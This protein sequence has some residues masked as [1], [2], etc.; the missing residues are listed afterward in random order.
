MSKTTAVLCAF[1]FTIGILILALTFV[2][3]PQTEAEPYQVRKSDTVTENS[4]GYLLSYY[5]TQTM[6]HG[7]YIIALVIGALTLISRWQKFAE[8]KGKEILSKRV[9]IRCRWIIFIFVISSIIA[10]GVYMIGRTL[11]WGALASKVM[12]TKVDEN[13]I[14]VNNIDKRTIMHELHKKTGIAV[15]TGNLTI[16]EQLA[17]ASKSDLLV[18]VGLIIGVL[19]VSMSILL[20]LSAW[21]GPLCP[22]FQL[23]QQDEERTERV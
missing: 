1:L 5:N 15:C 20:G 10:L 22:A 6:T 21:S 2:F 23:R 8:G 9:F 19:L 17:I 13:N 18:R 14:D 11:W 4:R 7:G 3:L 12:N 16:L